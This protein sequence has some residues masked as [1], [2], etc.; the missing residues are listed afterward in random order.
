MR[1]GAGGMYSAYCE[2]VG[3]RLLACREWGGTHWKWVGGCWCEVAEEV[4]VMERPSSCCF[5][6]G[7]AFPWCSETEMHLCSD[8]ELHW[9][10]EL[11]MN[12][13]SEPELHWCNELEMHWCIEPGVH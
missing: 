1:V 7:I 2:R 12:W 6:P 4:V 8:P 5:S 9:C 10:I 13:C 3:E 11:E